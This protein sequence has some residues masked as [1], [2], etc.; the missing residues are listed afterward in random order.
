M[1]L[2]FFLEEPSAREM[3]KGLLPRVLP[4]LVNIR[5]VVFEGKQDLKKNLIRRLRGWRAPS[6]VFVVMCDQDA[7]DCLAVKSE[8]AEICR[9]AGKPETVVRIVCRELESWYFGDLAAVESGFGISGLVRYGNVSQYRVPD[10]IRYPAVELRRI[11]R[12]AYQKVAGSRY[13]RLRPFK[14]G[15][16]FSQN[17]ASSCKSRSKIR[18]HTAGPFD[19]PT[20]PVLEEPRAARGEVRPTPPQSSQPLRSAVGKRSSRHGRVGALPR[21]AR[22]QRRDRFLESLTKPF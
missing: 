5:Y 16:N 6:G 21:L 15:S 14:C 4:C 1:N 19:F 22:P 13:C 8:L 3:L 2:V 18:S 17:R 9:D 7:A 11:T 10:N 12:N 20:E